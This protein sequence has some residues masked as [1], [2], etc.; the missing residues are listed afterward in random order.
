[1]KGAN[2]NCVSGNTTRTAR[3]IHGNGGYLTIRRILLRQ[4]MEPDKTY[5]VRMKSIIDSEKKEFQ[6]DYFEYCAKEVFDNPETPED[7]W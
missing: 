7:I 3:N 1:M 2:S 4:F 5:Y 6:L